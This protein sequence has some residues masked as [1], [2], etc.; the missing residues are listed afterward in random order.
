M[1]YV[2]VGTTYFD[3]LIHEVDNLAGRGVFSQEVV[4]Q[5]GRGSYKPSH[6]QWICYA[7]NEEYYNRADLVICH[8]GVGTVFE[9]LHVGKDF[10]TVANH[11][12]A[13][14]HQTA[15]LRILESHG[16]CTC[17]YDVLEIEQAYLLPRKT[18]PYQPDSS[19]ASAIWAEVT[20]T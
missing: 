17:C 18:K 6:I 5:I 14:D 10:I 3:E 12:L 20:G 7:D 13:R 4:A 1:I 16:W 8:G 15:L 11:A 19:L 2:T 9:L